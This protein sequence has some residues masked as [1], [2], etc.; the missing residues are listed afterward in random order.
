MGARRGAG[1]LALV[2][3]SGV[4]VVVA[5]ATRR[6][7][8]PAP[9]GAAGP[10]PASAPLAAVGSATAASAPARA[11]S[12]EADHE[13]SCSF[14]DRGNGA[15]GPWRAL[16]L[17]RLSAPEPLG[18]RVDVLL[19]L[20]GGEA[21]R[22]LLAPADLGLVLV[23]V[24]VGQGSRRYA[25]AFQAPEALDR[26]LTSIEREIGPARLG[27]VL[28]SAWSAGYGGVR[29]ILERQPERVAAIILLDAVHAGYAADGT[30]LAEAEI[31]P[32]VA[33]ARRAAAGETVMVLTH[34]EIRPPGYAATGEVAA[35]LIA[36]LDGRRRYAGLVPAFG[37]E[38]KTRF[39]RG[40]LHV[41][42]YTG[43]GKG[44]HCAQLELLVPIL[45]EVVLPALPPRPD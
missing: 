4:V 22:T 42:G 11:S 26:I 29:A 40:K 41:W 12:S 45:R 21:V 28:L 33:A 38:H 1:T 31:A 37:V 19:H 24:D 15:Y 39:D 2:V 10:M 43:T 44:A 17:G 16:G 18:T 20:H 8:D 35:E 5:L 13:P 36:R 7:A 3:L 23:A 14:P 32:F 34:S 27:R 6:V 25:E 30:S 9:A